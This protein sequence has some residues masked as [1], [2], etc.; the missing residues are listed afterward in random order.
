MDND[1]HI[2]VNTETWLNKQHWD[3]GDY[4]TFRTP[5]YKHQ[6]VLI[7]LRKGYFNNSKILLEQ[8]QSRHTLIVETYTA[9]GKNLLIIG[10]YAQ[11][12]IKQQCQQMMRLE[13]TG[14]ESFFQLRYKQGQLIQDLEEN[15]KPYLR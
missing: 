14:N 10:H 15:L 4:D 11:P 12:D 6:G 9:D 3:Y 8:L 13:P 7:A 1:I 2:A 5:D